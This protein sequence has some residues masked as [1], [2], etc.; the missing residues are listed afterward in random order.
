[1]EF[2]NKISF[3]IAGWIFLVAIVSILIALNSFLGTRT[4]SRLSNLEDGLVKLEN[5]TNNRLDKI[6]NKLDQILLNAKLPSDSEKSE[7]TNRTIQSEIDRDRGNRR[8]MSAP[9]MMIN[10]F[11]DKETMDR[12]PTSSE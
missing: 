3:L 7:K 8:I 2:F 11:K 5:N 12:K 1:M 9:K 10:S 4:Q 6:E